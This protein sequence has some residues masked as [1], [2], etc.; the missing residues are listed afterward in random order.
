M[1][2][3]ILFFLSATSHYV[4]AQGKF[5]GGDGDGFAAITISN[6]ALP[7]SVLEFVIS[8]KNNHVVGTCSLKITNETCSFIFQR[9]T[10]GLHFY[11]VDS[12]KS[13]VTYLN[14][15][16][17]QFLDRFSAKGINYYRVKIS[18]CSG[19]DFYTAILTLQM[20]NFNNQFQY[21]VLEKA[22]RYT[23]SRDC[24]FQIINNTGQIAFSK[25]IVAGSG[26]LSLPPMLH[27][28]YF[29]RFTGE[30]AHRVTVQ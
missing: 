13:D 21:S 18:Q 26:V 14:N 7:V 9:S 30:V 24:F 17:I 12:L 20:D 27:G 1:K 15:K 28:I 11:D 3:L 19:I 10:D 5:F 22:I 6:V 2:L 16:R 29:M 4:S 23:R 25:K 8:K